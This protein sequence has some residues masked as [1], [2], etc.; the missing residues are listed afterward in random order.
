MPVEVGDISTAIVD[1]RAKRTGGDIIEMETTVSTD[2]LKSIYDQEDYRGRLTVFETQDRSKAYMKVIPSPTDEQYMTDDIL[3]ILSKVKVT[4]GLKE[5]AIEA[6]AETLTKGGPAT[7]VILIAEGKSP[8]NGQDTSFEYGYNQE[9]PYVEPGQM[10]LRVKDPTD[11][12][13]GIDIGGDA[14]AA[15]PG[16]VIEVIA[17]DHVLTENNSEFTSEIFGMVNFENR[18]LEVNKVLDIKINDDEMEAALTYSG[19]TKLTR[20]KIIEELHAKSVTSGVDNKAIDF[21]VSEF[22]SHGKPIKN[23]CIARGTPSKPGR[24]GEIKY[25]FDTA[26]GPT[27]KEKKDGSI[28]IRETNIINCVKE[29]QEIAELIPH[30]E[31]TYGKSIFGQIIA[32]PKVNKVSLSV[33]KNVKVSSDGRH[34]FAELNGR[35]VIERGSLGH[36]I[37]VSEVFSVPGDLDLSIGNIDFDGVVEIGGDVEDGFSVKASKSITI[38]GVVGACNLESGLDITINGG[39]NGKEQ[40]QILCGQ[41]L[42]A[43]Y[44]NEVN[45]VCRGDITIHNEIVNSDVKTLGRITVGSGGNIRGGTVSAKQGIESYDIGSDMGVKTVLV[46]GEDYELLEKCKEIDEKII[47]INNEYSEISERIA[48][49]MK[50]KEL[51]GKLPQEQRDKLKDTVEHIQQLREE[52]DVLNKTKSELIAKAMATAKPEAIVKNHIYHS[53]ILKIGDSRREISSMLEGPL[54]LYEEEDRI[55]VEP[56]FEK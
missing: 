27:F 7:D 8:V 38:M 6:A 16:T 42:E 14:I 19:T 25:F 48:P 40:A 30:I 28:D 34:F 9:D 45:V 31:P 50:N 32:P 1:I 55:T 17:G 56:F 15:S 11:G 13:D 37:S 39:C 20:E 47:D 22:N 46:P 36:R 54:R 51:L 35:P 10:I 26:D 49:L 2:N 41:N 21:I 44:L 3:F 29:N 5:D 24:D 12:Q 23:F 18:L 53:V 4:Y 43:R 52:K 33:G